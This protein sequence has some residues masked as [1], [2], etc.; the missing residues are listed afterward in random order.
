M[1]IGKTINKLRIQENLSQEQ[2]AELFGVSRQSVQKWESDISVPELSKLIKIV[3][4]FNI[5]LDLLLLD[6]NERELEDKADC[7]VIQPNYGKDNY[8]EN[9]ETEYT[10]SSEEGLDIKEYEN[11]FKTI[12][13]LP[14]GKIKK[15]FSDILFDIVCNAKTV[16]DYQYT[17][18]SDI[19]EIKCLRK[20]SEELPAVNKDRLEEKISGAWMGRIC[21][22][23]LGKTVEGIKTDE[24]V[25]FLKE[26]NNY[27][28]HRYILHSDINDDILSRYKF[29]FAR[30]CYADTSD[31]MPTDDDTNYVVLAQEVINKYGRDFTHTM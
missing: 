5:S 14:K 13:S 11:L 21:G 1:T 15:R 18:P 27:P 24:L 3:K 2:F 20:D 4:H 12:S 6:R 29:G 25:S 26:T 10:Q 8:T 17:E 31:G 30:R 28:M 22:C 9:L 16:K 19:D 7:E 23:L